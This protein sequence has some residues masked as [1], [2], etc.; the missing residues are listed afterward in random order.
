M[1]IE[2]IKIARL[3]KHLFNQCALLVELKGDSQAK[4]LIEAEIRGIELS[5]LV[6]G[7]EVD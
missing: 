5:L 2:Q 3:L 1:K 6:L 4:D 7:I